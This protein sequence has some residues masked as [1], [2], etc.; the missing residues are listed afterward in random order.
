MDFLFLWRTCVFAISQLLL[1]GAYGLWWWKWVVIIFQYTGVCVC[2]PTISRS[3]RCDGTAAAAL[4]SEKYCAKRRPLQLFAHETGVRM[5]CAAR[6]K[7]FKSN[8]Y[9]FMWKSMHNIFVGCNIWGQRVKSKMDF[10]TFGCCCCTKFVL[11]WS[12]C[13]VGVDGKEGPFSCQIKKN[14]KNIQSHVR[15]TANK[16][17]ETAAAQCLAM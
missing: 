9:Y 6:D 5:L 13:V 11:R 16:K 12:L 3:L 17:K 14:L 1:G 8:F 2:V 10:G 15:K 4:F 7:S